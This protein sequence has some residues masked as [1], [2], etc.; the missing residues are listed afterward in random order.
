MKSLQ[1]F[2]GLF[3]GLLLSGTGMQAQSSSTNQAFWIHED[4]VKPSMYK[5]YEAVTKDFIAACKEHNLQDADFT[6]ARLD[7]GIYLSISPISKM[8]DLDNNPLAP[9][10]EKMGEEKFREMFTRFDKCYDS[11]RNYVVHLVGNMSYLPNSLSPNTP[12]EDYRKWHFFHV[13]PQNVTNLRNKMMEIRSLYEEKAAP[14]HYRIYRNGFGTTGDYF[15]VVISAKDA[16]SYLETSEETN[17]LLGEQGEKLMNEMMQ[18]V[19]K[20][21]TKTGKMRPDLAY[22]SA[23]PIKD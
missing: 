22:T 19:S 17:K 9:M 7:E 11:H 1:L 13:S 2:M 5:E 18:Y 6:T 8:G 12:G 14:Q 23:A 15:L 10:A 21:E 4:Q 3:V 20:Y 16:K